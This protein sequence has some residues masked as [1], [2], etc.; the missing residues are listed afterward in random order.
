MF[1]SWPCFFKFFPSLFSISQI[2][3]SFC[4]QCQGFREIWQDRKERAIQFFCFASFRQ[5]KMTLTPLRILAVSFQFDLVFQSNSSKTFF[6]FCILRSWK[7]MFYYFLVNVISIFV[8]KKK[9]T[10]HSNFWFFPITIRSTKRNGN[11][12]LTKDRCIYLQ[13][14]PGFVL[15]RK[16]VL[17]T[18][19]FA[20][21]VIQAL[22]T[23]T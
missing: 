9:K 18:R 19:M 5:Y 23:L 6:F 16:I 4:C 13:A 22:I 11:C 21:N 1:Y 17:S 10:V 12:I 20:L 7:N 8:K 3:D 15:W 14:T 2:I